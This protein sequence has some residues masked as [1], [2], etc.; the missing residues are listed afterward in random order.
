MGL[1]K[2][3]QELLDRC[4]EV[5]KELLETNFK[6]YEANPTIF[7]EDLIYMSVVNRT[8]SLTH[9]YLCLID[10]KNYY[11]AMHLIRLI[12]DSAIRFSAIWFVSNR[13]DFLNHFIDGRDIRQY[14]DDRGKKLTDINLV[15]RLSE[16]FN[17][18]GLKVAYEWLC[19]IV[20]FNSEH[21]S[22]IN[23]PEDKRQ[24]KIGF[25]GNIMTDPEKISLHQKLFYI[26]TFV[27]QICRSWEVERLRRLIKADNQKL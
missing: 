26:V 19:S 21:L 2:E 14:K 15:N 17:D 18:P 4:R 1:L 6:I 20:H 7:Q 23:D 10:V 16:Y 3:E 25:E 13:R 27:R 11:S 9:G 12:F 8:N 5:N 22:S 24:I